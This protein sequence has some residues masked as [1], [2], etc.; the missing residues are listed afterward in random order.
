[1]DRVSG[2]DSVADLIVE[3]LRTS[4]RDPI[5]NLIRRIPL[6]SYDLLDCWKWFPDSTDD[7]SIRIAVTYCYCMIFRGEDDRYSGV[8]RQTT[9]LYKQLWRGSSARKNE[10]YMLDI[11]K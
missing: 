9:N 10:I 8:M 11:H 6:A 3:F 2:I 5:V 4:F 1:M 7:Y